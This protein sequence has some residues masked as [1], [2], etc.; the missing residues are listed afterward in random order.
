MNLIVAVDKNFGI[1]NEGNLLTYIPEDLED[2]KKKTIGKVVVMGRTTLE[3]LPNKA[4]LKNR[5]N[6]ILTRDEDY[7]VED[8]I[9]VSSL[10]TLFEIL[11]SYNSKDIFII[12][13]ES[14]YKKLEGYCEFAYVT[15]INNTYKSDRHFLNIDEDKKWVLQ[16]RGET[17]TSSSGVSFNFNIYRNTKIL[18]FD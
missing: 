16:N 12:G 13:G 6:I 5:I 3:Y 10:E 17:I 14:I 18:N 2:F 9:V 11:K 8:A 15:K 7:K 4:A 1:G